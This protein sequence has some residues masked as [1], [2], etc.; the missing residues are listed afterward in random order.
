LT[1]KNYVWGGTFKN[2]NQI[3]VS[4]LKKE[5]FSSIFEMSSWNM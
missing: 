2:K 1:I 4:T 5:K 3:F